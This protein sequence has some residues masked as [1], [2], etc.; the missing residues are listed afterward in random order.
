M[1]LDDAAEELASTLG[2]DKT[3]VKADLEKLVSYS[4]PMDEA[5]QSLRRKHGGS[6]GGSDGSDTPPKT[7]IADI[8]PETGNV[9][10]TAR[11]MTV[12]KRSIRYEG[13]DQIIFEGELAD[14][15]ADDAEDRQRKREGEGG[16][17]VGEP[18][19]Q[20]RRRGQRRQPQ[21]QIRHQPDDDQQV[22]HPTVGREAVII[23]LSHRLRPFVPL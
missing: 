8:T 4:V 13:E 6:E 7:D 5:K 2:V 20:R 3:E 12:G 18:G 9:T 11:V 16:A 19:E 21:R 14:E 23:R 10:V 22:L 17:A 1:S 15:I